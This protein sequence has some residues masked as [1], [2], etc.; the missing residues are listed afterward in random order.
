MD[1]HEQ[2]CELT[3]PDGYGKIDAGLFVEA[4]RDWKLVKPQAWFDSPRIQLPFTEAPPVPPPAPENSAAA[5]GQLTQRD[6]EVNEEGGDSS[7]QADESDDASSDAPTNTVDEP[8]PRPN[9][10]FI[11]KEGVSSTYEVT[12]E[13]LDNENFETLEHVT[14]R[15]WIEH[16]RRG[17]VEVI[18]TSPSGKESVLARP[19]RYDESGTGFRGWKF[20]TLKHWEENPIGT[21]TITVKDQGS[22]RGRF[23]AWALQLWG[24]AKDASI[25]T[26]W[27]PAKAGEID[28]ELTGSEN[29]PKPSKP[30]PTD[31]LPGDHGESIPEGGNKPSNLP[32]ENQAD[33]G[34]F[35]GMDKLK[36]H[37]GWVGGALLVVVLASVGVGAL[38]FVRNRRR[39]SRLGLDRAAYAPVAEEVPLGFME[40]SR[41]RLGMGRDR[42]AEEAKELYDA[43]GDGPSDDD[44]DDERAALRYHDSF[45]ED[46]EPQASGSGTS[47]KLSH[48]E[49]GKDV[50][51]DDLPP[52]YRDEDDAGTPRGESAGSSSSWQ[53]AADDVRR[54]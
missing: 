30:K 43:F 2:E 12:Q 37:P 24:E 44:S 9:G 21:W 25:A 26:D 40:R 48:E 13:L 17:D 50:R 3:F 20:M 38:F 6:D 5:N 53:D 35:N 22:A 46:D 49:G 23:I 34:V 39:R 10:S 19:R 11:T 1:R 8:G 45:L 41:Q 27:S 54:E 16:E 33:E 29:M 15:V 28:E 7:D 47:G 42:R 52:A 4:C 36:E 32:G 18:L 14:V 51:D 31:L